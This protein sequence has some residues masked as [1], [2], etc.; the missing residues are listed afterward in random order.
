MYIHITRRTLIQL[1]GSSYDTS[2]YLSP[3][4]AGSRDLYCR[5]ERKIVVLHNYSIIFNTELTPY[6]PHFVEL[7]IKMVNV[8]IVVRYAH[9]SHYDRVLLP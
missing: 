5:G 8:F 9:F 1:G 7:N 2:M 6:T 4:L 3:R